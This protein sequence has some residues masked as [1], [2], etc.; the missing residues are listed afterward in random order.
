MELP[1]NNSEDENCNDKLND[2]GKY[3][4]HNSD[5]EIVFWSFRDKK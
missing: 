1:V 4:V 2:N 3:F 5:G